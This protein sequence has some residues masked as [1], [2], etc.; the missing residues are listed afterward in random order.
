[1]SA[2]ATGVEPVVVHGRDDGAITVALMLLLVLTLAGAA[3]VVDGGRVLAA[4][5]HASNVA[6]A[7][8]RAGVSTAGPLQAID[9]NSAREAAL[10]HAVRAGIAPR[11]VTIVVTADRVTV[12]VTE[13]RTTVFLVLGGLETT[14]VRAEGTARRAWDG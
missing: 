7:A 3:L 13:R 2:E 4:R 6:E 14:T 11:D 1:M 9:P 10:D 5:R 12:T 8:A